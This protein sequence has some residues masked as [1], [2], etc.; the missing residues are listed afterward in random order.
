MLTFLICLG[1]VLLWSPAASGA[2]IPSRG[3]VPM[4]L[5]PESK[6]NQITRGGATSELENTGFEMAIAG[7]VAT[8]IGDICMH[9][10]DCIKT[11][12]QSNA[13]AGLSMLGASKQILSSQGVGGFY[14]GLGTYV[15]SD[16]FAGSIKFFTY[17]ALKKAIASNLPEDKEKAKS[18]ERWGLFVAAGAAFIAS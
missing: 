16:G 12:Q 3:K 18:R 11:L 14:A 13:G 8:M 5:V 15:L 9:P 7:A 6:T 1:M 4:P 2:F 10:I 17:E